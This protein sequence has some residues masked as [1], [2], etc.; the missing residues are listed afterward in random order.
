MIPLLL[1]LVALPAADGPIAMPAHFDA[2]LVRVTPETKDG[3]KLLLYTDS[4]GGL[5]L[6]SAAVARLGLAT[7]TNPGDAESGG[8]PY[9]L[10]KLPALKP[11]A[12]IPA[13]NESQSGFLVM[14]TEMLAKQGF[15]G[16]ED[17]LLGQSWFGGRVWTW[18]YPAGH[19]TLEGSTW[20]PD[21]SATRVPIG[22]REDT[23]F[24][25]ISIRVD[26]KDF[27]VLLDTGAMTTLKPAALAALGDK[28]PAHRATSMIVD[29]L[30]T[31]WR[32]KHPDWRVIDDAQE[33]SGAA[34][35]EVPAVG[36]GGA[37]VGPVWF[38][39]RPDRNFHD[40][41]SSM[42]D[43]KVEG[44]I[45]GNALSHFAMTVDYPGKAA[46]FRCTRDC[47]VKP[48]PAHGSPRAARSP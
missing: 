28:G 5:F 21:A 34:M 38:T 48:Q 23:S 6:T 37:T 10:A 31:A 13:P 30:F 4:G 16:E 7:E 39:W 22:L 17:G 2:N 35:I 8:K 19:L 15:T 46:Y 45:G 36:I 27:D 42:M 29:S 44:A 26:G 41:M 32:T 1:A 24:P 9:E 18:D 43:G 40:G 47:G 33:R 11:G 25:R 14:P 3:K 12:W 20:K